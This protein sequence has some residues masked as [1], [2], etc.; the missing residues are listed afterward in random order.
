[1]A[2]L[3][4]ETT[5][6]GTWERDFSHMPHAVTPMFAAIWPESFEAGFAESFARYGIP[7]KCAGMQVINRFV[8][9]SGVPLGADEPAGT[10]DL[11]AEMAARAAAAEAAFA[12]KIWRRQLAEWD[13]VAKPA[14]MAAHAA[15]AAVDL[16]A[17]SDDALA[18]HLDACIE[19]HRAMVVQHHRFNAAAMIPVGDFV[20]HVTRWSGLQA[21]QLMSI[22]EGYSPISG[23]WSAEIAPA[24]EAIAAHPTVRS[25]L[26]GPDDPAKRLFALRQLLPEV[27]AYLRSV[28]YRV[29]DSFDITSPT[30][31]E[32]PGLALGKLRS[33][34]ERGGPQSTEA[35]DARAAELRALVPAEHR[36]EFDDLLIEARLTYR[37]RDDRGV[38]SDMSS[39]GLLRL[40]LLELGRRLVRAG[41]AEQPEHALMLDP[42][43]T[44]AVATG[45]GGPTAQELAQRWADHHAPPAVEPP[46]RLGPPP[47]P[48]PPPDALPAPMARAMMA[49]K[50]HSGQTPAA[51]VPDDDA[52]PLRGMCGHPGRYTGTARVIRTATDLL[53]VEPGDVI[54]TVSTSEAFNAAIFL[55]G[56]IVTDHG[57]L[58]SHAAIVARE[59]GIPAVVGARTATTRISTGD[60]IDVDAT[61]GTVTVLP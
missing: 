57:G 49:F 11:E 37:L 41:H 42:D 27:D 29:V 56:A 48:P 14:A 38:C 61:E 28:S 51:D 45:R 58:T 30:I 59:V 26:D 16:P 46:R 2:G 23:V 33:A 43:E 7:M 25:L 34:V 39:A 15:L 52:G 4:F 18:L 22:F 13:D 12:G 19:H 32:L 17:L 10:F 3:T 54:V 9:M 36:A 55:A 21:P 1:M 5:R 31:G 35:A 53:D 47:T 20:E 44:V 24:A 6:P 60:L 50:I 8:Y 40:A